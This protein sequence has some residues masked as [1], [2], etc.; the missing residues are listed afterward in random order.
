MGRLRAKSAFPYASD[1]AFALMVL[2]GGGVAVQ[3]G[4]GQGRGLV[5]Q[6]RRQWRQQCWRRRSGQTAA[7]AVG[8]QRLK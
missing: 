6:W 3:R 2:C 1:I 7:V 5:G 4:Q 8:G